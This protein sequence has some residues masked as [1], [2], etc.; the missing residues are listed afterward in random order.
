MPEGC[1]DVGVNLSVHLLPPA[2]ECIVLRQVAL[3]HGV[4]HAIEHGTVRLEVAILVVVDAVELGVPFEHAS[5]HVTLNHQESGRS[6]EHLDKPV[7]HLTVL[8][9][10]VHDERAGQ[11]VEVAVVAL[12]DSLLGLVPHDHLFRVDGA[13]NVVA[14]FEQSDDR[15]GIKVNIGVDKQKKVRLGLGH[16]SRNR[17]VTGSVD[18][19]LVL[20]RVEH[21]LNAA[22]GAQ[23]LKFQ[24]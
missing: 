18:Q 6:V 10:E 21:E 15:H 19:R 4:N 16:E 17:Q 14:A 22:N 23:M 13:R 20:G 1:L 24:N 5:E 9:L 7:H 8:V 3:R 12:A 2:T 11:L